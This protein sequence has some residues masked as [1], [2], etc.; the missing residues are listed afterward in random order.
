MPDQIYI[1]RR[2]Y[3]LLHE[4]Y[5]KLKDEMP[6]LQTEIGREYEGGDNFHD[7]G[8]WETLVRAMSEV[9]GRL[10]EIELALNN[11][12]IIDDLEINA[13]VVSVGTTVEVE[14]VATGEK[15]TY[16]ILGPFETIL[17][18]HTEDDEMIIVVSNMSPIAE[19]LMGATTDDIRH[20][21]H[22]RIDRKLRIISIRCWRT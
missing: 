13:N 12:A 17:K 7:N 9:R 2:C 18:D 6:Q 22:Q 4:N 10:A 11:G 15:M 14:N 5:R 16:T 21:K 20:F 19:A 8:S 3:N 1:T